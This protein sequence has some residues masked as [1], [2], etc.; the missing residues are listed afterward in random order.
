MWG[1][2]A[3]VLLRGGPARNALSDGIRDLPGDSV[4][5]SPPQCANKNK[6]PAQ[7]CRVSLSPT[8][9]FFWRHEGTTQYVP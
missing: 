3:L 1:T 5:M 2:E 8:A 9:R 4:R 7:A 6:K